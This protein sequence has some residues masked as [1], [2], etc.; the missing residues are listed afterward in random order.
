MIYNNLGRLALSENH[1]FRGD[2]VKE[3]LL[4]LYYLLCVWW[5]Q[6]KIAR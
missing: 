2:S 5:Q 1:D 4:V 6:A 3:G